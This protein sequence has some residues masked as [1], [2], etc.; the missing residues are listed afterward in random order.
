MQDDLRLEP[1]RGEIHVG[2]S[3]Q[4]IYFPA[5]GLDISNIGKDI[6]QVQQHHA[7][8]LALDITSGT[9]NVCLLSHQHFADAATG[10]DIVLPFEK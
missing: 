2:G 7:A 6:E 3:F 5:D 8:S 9:S 4:D 1:R 10:S